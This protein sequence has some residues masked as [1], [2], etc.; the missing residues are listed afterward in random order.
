[1]PSVFRKKIHSLFVPPRYLADS[2]SGIDISTSSVKAVRLS[3]SGEGLL[4]TTYAEER[5][6]P[7]AV[8]DGEIINSD[9]VAEKLAAVA[10]A[11]G[12]FATNIA[13][14]ESKTPQEQTVEAVLSVCDQA[15]IE[16]R[17]IEEESRATARAL[18]RKGDASTVMIVDI[19]RATTKLIII[20]GHTPQFSKTVSIGGHSLTLAVQKYFGVTE[21]E[22]REIKSEQGIISSLEN[23]DC[24]AAMLQTASALRKEISNCL[25]SWQ[26]EAHKRDP[27]SRIILVGGNA[28]LRG[29]PEYFE[30][31]LQIPVVTGDVFTHFASRDSWIPQL[32]H[33]ESLA[34]A[35]AIG[36]ALYDSS[37]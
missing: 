21:Q 13:L 36:L 33:N 1:M 23:K 25:D 34:Y 6:P 9:A 4:L 22:A 18:F 7:G 28:S 29:L 26:H 30:E 27:I 37:Q 24:V 16:V 10:K 5:L 32:N 2:F 12:I 17:A 20:S 19:G 35:T 14:P 3:E 15:K 11:T 8:V 31:E